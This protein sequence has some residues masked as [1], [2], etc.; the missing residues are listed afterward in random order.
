MKRGTESPSVAAAFYNTVQCTRHSRRTDC[1]LCHSTLKSF[2]CVLAHFIQLFYCGAEQWFL[3]TDNSFSMFNRK[4]FWLSK[5]AAKQEELEGQNL[6]FWSLSK[7]GRFLFVSLSNGW[8]FLGSG[9]SGAFL[10]PQMAFPN[11]PRNVMD[12]WSCGA[13]QAGLTKSKG[14]N[15]IKCIAQMLRTPALQLLCSFIHVVQLR[16]FFLLRSCTRTTLRSKQ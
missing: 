7:T 4:L 15:I 14:S 3:R 13:L 10:R 11:L 1:L 5:A 9:A 6:R 16:L 12:S 2:T 8:P